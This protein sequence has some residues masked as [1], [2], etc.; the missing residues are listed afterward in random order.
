V[1]LRDGAYGKR[2]AAKVVFMFDRGKKMQ[3]I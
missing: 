1:L 2:P 3:G